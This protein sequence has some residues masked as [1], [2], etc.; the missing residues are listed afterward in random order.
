MYVIHPACALCTALPTAA[1]AADAVPSTAGE[2]SPTLAWFLV[3]GLAAVG[4]T[5]TSVSCCWV[6]CLCRCLLIAYLGVDSFL[7]ATHVTGCVA[8]MAWT[9]MREKLCYDASAPPR[10]LTLLHR[11]QFRAHHHRAVQLRPHARHH[12]QV[13]SA[14]R[15]ITSFH[16]LTSETRRLTIGA[17]PTAIA[18]ARSAALQSWA[19]AKHGDALGYRCAA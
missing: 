15:L 12:L 17:M 5:I 14:H 4:F 13:W 11:P 3:V 6:I 18:A 1:T 16:I 10:N 2:L 19:A 7:Q 8:A 9:H